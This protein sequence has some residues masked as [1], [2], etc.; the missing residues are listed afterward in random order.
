MQMTQVAGLPVGKASLQALEPGKR[1]T[2]TEEGSPASANG[3]SMRQALI[4]GRRG[5]IVSTRTSRRTSGIAG[6]ETAHFSAIEGV[7]RWKDVEAMVIIGRPLPK[8]DAIEQRRPLSP[9]SRSLPVP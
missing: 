8:S 3:W 7:D 5:L 9:A 2:E 4:Q 1:T 6:I